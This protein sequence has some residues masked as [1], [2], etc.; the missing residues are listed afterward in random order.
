[1]SHVAAPPAPAG[2]GVPA[3]RFPLCAGPLARSCSHLYR[4]SL[5]LVGCLGFTGGNW[6][7]SFSVE[8]PGHGTVCYCDTKFDHGIADKNIATAQGCKTVVQ[9]TPPRCLPLRA[10]AVLSAT[11]LAIYAR[12]YVQA[13]QRSCASQVGLTRSPT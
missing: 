4:P 2:R 1:M 10:A 3:W 5:V 13:A 11:L 7:D 6:H 12:A 8:V 9:C